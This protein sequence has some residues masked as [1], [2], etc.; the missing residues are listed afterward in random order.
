MNP[1]NE[2][3]SPISL[4]YN[5]FVKYYS[6]TRQEK[7]KSRSV[8]PESQLIKIMA[9]CLQNCRRGQ[10]GKSTTNEGEG[11]CFC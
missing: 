6:K 5:G 8:S 9:E 4:S 10:C 2:S 7:T 1:F 3:K 11:S